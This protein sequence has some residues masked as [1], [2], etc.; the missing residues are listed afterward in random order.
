M[1]KNLVK[2]EKN[3]NDDDPRFDELLSVTLIS[4][5]VLNIGIITTKT[6]INSILGI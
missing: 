5:I 3:N 2:K 1:L 6:G 4:S